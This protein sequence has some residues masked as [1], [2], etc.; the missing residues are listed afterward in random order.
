MP[1]GIG[2]G[3]RPSPGQLDPL[4]ELGLTMPTPSAGVPPPPPP[5]PGFQSQQGMAPAAPAPFAPAPAPGAPGAVP[6]QGGLAADPQVAQML[7]GKSPEELAALVMKVKEFN[8]RGGAGRG[9]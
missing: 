1:P 9:M 6:M 4:D 2:Y 7:Q 3:S 8:A 5:A